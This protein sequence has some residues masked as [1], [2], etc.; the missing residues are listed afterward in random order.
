MQLLLNVPQRSLVFIVHSINILLSFPTERL[1]MPM[2]CNL[3][4]FVSLTS[5][6]SGFCF[7]YWSF[8]IAFTSTEV[9]TC[10]LNVGSQ[11][12]LTEIPLPCSLCVVLPFQK[13]LT[14]GGLGTSSPKRI[15]SLFLQH[16]EWL[17]AVCFKIQQ[18]EWTEHHL[19]KWK[20]GNTVVRNRVEW[21]HW[22]HAAPEDTNSECLIKWDNAQDILLNKKNQHHKA[23]HSIV[24]MCFWEGYKKRGRVTA[25][26]FNVAYFLE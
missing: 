18:K 15:W 11:W 20:A 10:H 6:T 22:R 16:E 4:C 17:R 21:P 24:C 13:G 3:T 1:E 23:V 26:P 19:Q 8:R 9:E 5:T 25:A 12:G 2:S 7:A 14:L